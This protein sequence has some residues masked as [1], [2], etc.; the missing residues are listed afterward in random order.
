MR[1]E[2]TLNPY[3]GHIFAEVR[4]SVLEGNLARGDSNPDPGPALL[5]DHIA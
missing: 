2:V 3:C 5:Q 4:P 1:A